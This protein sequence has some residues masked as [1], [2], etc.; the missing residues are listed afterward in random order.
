MPLLA[1]LASLLA[2]ALWGR[3]AARRLLPGANGADRLVAGLLAGTTVFLAGPLWIGILTGRLTPGLV[4]AGQGALAAVAGW[5]L[6]RPSG[7]PDA[8]PWRER[9]RLFL[10]R[11]GWAWGIVLLWSAAWAAPGWWLSPRAAD[12]IEYHSTQPLHWL[13]T[14]EFRF[15]TKGP[16]DLV[17]ASP[18]GETQPNLKALA[19]VQLGWLRGDLRGA[20]LVQAWFLLV[21]LA[22]IRAIARRFDVPEGWAA[23]GAAAI[24]GTTDVMLQ[25]TELYADI[26]AAAVIA[27]ALWALVMLADDG[28]RR[29]RIG[30]FALAAGH[31][32][33]AKASLLFAGAGLGVLALVVVAFKAGAGHR[34]RRVALAAGLS[35]GAVAALGGPWYAHGARAFGNPVYPYRVSVGERVLLPGTFAGGINRQML[36]DV[37]GIT[38]GEAYRRS[39]LETVGLTQT[40]YRFQGLGPVWAGLM[41]PAAA[42]AIVMV[43]DQREARRRWLLLL[44]ALAATVVGVPDLWWP[45]FALTTGTIGA[46]G[47]ALVAAR[48][49]PIARAWI[50]TAVVA[51]A[52]WNGWR[53]VPSLVLQRREPALAFYPLVTGDMAPQL[54]ERA[55]GL[56]VATDLAAG[57]GPEAV[58]AYLPRVHAAPAFAGETRA[59]AMPGIRDL[60]G[61]D[62]WIEALRASPA[63]HVLAKEDSAELKALRERRRE[64][65]PVPLPGLLPRGHVWDPAM[66]RGDALFR[67]RREE[68]AP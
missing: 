35:L 52:L 48:G 56:V 8:R 28:A 33:A 29:G 65:P 10:R 27:L 61:A 49:G 38:V 12:A 66:P 26:Q 50:V 6:S 53:A 13:A 25:S 46:I 68:A 5:L 60:G 45:R 34:V 15:S 67:I 3:W 11:G 20:G 7:D 59:L 58:V 31:I 47:I 17:E 63:T 41:A 51:A 4:A 57:L 23:A 18:R 19:V 40:A 21:W 55:P 16:L 36:R 14:G 44:A 30:A 62:A 39:L 1:I 54:R 43:W 9:G 24:A 37:F 64:F 42:L 32:A 2:A 22:A